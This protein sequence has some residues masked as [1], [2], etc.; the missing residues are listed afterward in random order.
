[1]EKNIYFRHMTTTDGRRFTVA[2]HYD[3]KFDDIVVGISLCGDKDNFSRLSGRN[4][5][6]GRSLAKV[7]TR[8]RSII[9]LYEKTSSENYW[10][11]QET[12]VFNEKVN[13]FGEKTFEELKSD[14]R[15]KK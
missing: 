11:G 6:A 7:G 13:R 14:F 4:R 8:G 3:S 1:M 9:S 10:V 12:K 15:L 5:S 2:G